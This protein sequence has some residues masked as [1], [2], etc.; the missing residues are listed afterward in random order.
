[1]NMDLLPSGF[2]YDN[3]QQ[4]ISRRIGFRHLDHTPIE[5]PMNDTTS[6]LRYDIRCCYKEY[7]AHPWGAGSAAIELDPAKRPW[8]DVFTCRLILPPTQP[9]YVDMEFLG[10]GLSWVG[11]SRAQLPMKVTAQVIITAGK[12]S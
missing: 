8:I 7:Y 5:L 9:N 2:N 11:I 3:I 12:S 10:Y 6:D 4:R 1:M